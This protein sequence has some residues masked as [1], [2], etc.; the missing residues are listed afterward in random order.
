MELAEKNWYSSWFDTPYYHILYKNRGDEEAQNFMKNLVSF[1]K[2]KPGATILDL[3]CGRGRHS[4]FLNK[5]GFDVTG[6]DLSENNIA[7]AKQF[8]NENLHFATH[9]MCE[10]VN[11]KFDAVFNLFT[12]IGYFEEEEDNLRTIMSIKEELKPE[13]FGVI[14]FMNVKKVIKDLIP[15]EVKTVKGIEFDISRS[16]KDG[17]IVKDIRFE[18]EGE[19]HLFTEKV[20]ALTLEGFQEYFEKAGIELLHIFGN[21]ELQDFNEQ[22]SDRLILIFN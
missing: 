12:S 10:P 6:V 3:A 4:R 13:G 9:C 19:E 7:Y 21:Y 22:T 8:E 16:V 15:E 1:L 20:K 14:D 2:L 17:Y 18:D 11:E 5:E